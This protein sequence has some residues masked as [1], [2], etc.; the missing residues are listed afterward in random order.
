MKLIILDRDGVINHDSSDFIKAPEEW[1]PIPG[2]LEAIA[3]LKKAGWI[4]T[5]ATNQSGLSRGLFDETTLE[6][7]HQHMYRH[8]TDVGASID[9]LVWCPH[10]PN[11]RCRCRKP[12]PG[13]YLQIAD[14]FKCC[15][16]NVPIVGDSKR[17]LDAA[18][19]VGASPILVETGKGLKS[20][21]EGGLPP[22]TVKFANLGSVVKTLLTVPRFNSELL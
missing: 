6:L 15:L 5:V 21:A 4:V 9:Y 8:L 10:G 2:S 11:D 12:E 17:D 3:R 16:H 20:F 13:M 14:Y 1:L 19:A 22:E 7:I 18:V